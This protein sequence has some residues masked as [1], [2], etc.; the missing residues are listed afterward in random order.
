ML[1]FSEISQIDP[2]QHEDF[3]EVRQL[4][5]VTDLFL[6]RAHYGHVTGC[7]NNYMI[8]YLFGSR[9]GI[10]IFDLE[11]TVEHFQDALNFAAH[12]AYRKGI[13]LFVD[14]SKQSMPFVEKTAKDCGEYAHCRYWSP[15]IFTDMVNRLGQ[16]IRLPDLVI[17]LNTQNS[18]FQPHRAVT[19][20]AKMLIP[21]I[22]VVDSNC[23]PRLISY[24]IP[25]NDDTLMSKLYYL[26]L[27]EAAIMKGK[28]KQILNHTI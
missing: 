4:V 2:L 6:H 22:G 25:A 3:F 11:Q 20:C 12:I 16:N 1:Y 17:F 24:P 27:F 23:D 8:P 9:S 14:R 28:S 7:R 19:D 5:T 18:V 26:K 10:D 13:I 21:T 15:G